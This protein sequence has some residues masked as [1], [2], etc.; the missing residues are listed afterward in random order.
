MVVIDG[1]SMQQITNVRM[2]VNLDEKDSRIGC[3]T[4]LT[5]SNPKTLTC[6][7][8]HQ[9]ARVVALTWHDVDYE[10]LFFLNSSNL[11]AS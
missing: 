3:K 10:Q 7:T 2:K 11:H 8:T 1:T 6:T 9:G 5:I 4:R